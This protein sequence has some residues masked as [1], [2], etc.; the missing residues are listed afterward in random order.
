MFHSS[1]E[2]TNLI[3]LKE[4]VALNIQVCTGFHFGPCVVAL[5]CAA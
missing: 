5:D 4:Q 2:L 3:V 1:D